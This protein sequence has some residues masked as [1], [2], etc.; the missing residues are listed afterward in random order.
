MCRECVRLVHV[1]DDTLDSTSDVAARAGQRV[2]SPALDMLKWTPPPCLDGFSQRLVPFHACEVCARVEF[3][4]R[5]R[6]RPS[7][8]A[9]FASPKVRFLTLLVRSRVWQS[10][11]FPA[12]HCAAH[13][14]SP[15]SLSPAR[16]NT[17]C[18]PPARSK[19]VRSV[20]QVDVAHRCTVCND[21][22][23]SRS[24]AALHHCRTTPSINCIDFSAVIFHTPTHPRAS[25]TRL[26]RLQTVG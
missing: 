9:T 15:L 25:V 18:E 19:A 10:E 21:L 16:S 7:T 24:C 26:S 23:F 12:S 11:R 3:S 17:L 1:I 5:L 13:I 6:T 22:F 20:F 14:A 4:A 8:W 2:V